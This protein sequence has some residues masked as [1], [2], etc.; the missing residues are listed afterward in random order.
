MKR[1]LR[2]G[3]SFAPVVRGEADDHREFAVSARHKGVAHATDATHSYA[4]WPGGRHEP[5]LFN[6]QEDPNQEINACAERP[7]VAR[8]YHDR[9]IG[10]LSEI[11]APDEVIE[12]CAKP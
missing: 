11:N 3:R 7:E 2:T 1:W 12:G 4:T 6:L 9:L 5:V 10:F 8:E